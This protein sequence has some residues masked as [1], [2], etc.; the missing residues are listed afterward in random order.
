MKCCHTVDVDICD[1]KAI[2]IDIREPKAR[3]SHVCDECNKE[4]E[5]GE[6]Y[7]NEV[8]RYDGKLFHHKLCDDCLSVREVFFSS[9]WYYGT[10]WEDMV[11]F[12][13]N[14][15]GEISNSQLQMVTETA[16]TTILDLIDQYFEEH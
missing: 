5:K 13:E 7:R 2:I 15:D 11:T 12:I 4:I 14:C 10:I 3:I 16:K 1:E 8:L 6:E 9:G